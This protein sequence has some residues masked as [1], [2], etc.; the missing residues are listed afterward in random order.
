M[1]S[2]VRSPRTIALTLTVAALLASSS[3]TRAQPAPAEPWPDGESVPVPDLEAEWYRGPLGWIAVEEPGFAARAAREMR[4]AA[5]AWERHFGRPAPKGAVIDV[6]FADRTRAMEE[7]GADWVLAYPF[8]RVAEVAGEARREDGGADG[9]ED[10]SAA[11]RSEI[12]ARLEARG[13]DKSDDEI[14]GMVE[15]AL[16]RTS[17]E[18]SRSPTPDTRR[19]LRHEIGHDLFEALL[20]PSGEEETDRYGTGAPDWLDETAAVLMEGPGHTESRREVFLRAVEAGETIPLAE[21]FE[22]E[23]PLSGLDELRAMRGSTT[24]SGGAVVL[25]GEEIDARLGRSKYF[26]AQARGLADFLLKRSGEP[27]LLA[28]ITRALRSG[29]A[30]DEWLGREGA[31]HGLPAS[32]PALEDAFLAWARTDPYGG[33]G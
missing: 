22:M 5:R 11:I 10:R 15:R 21:F 1:A 3:A 33:D 19:A 27:T 8:R 26:Y 25:S 29:S 31:D 24:G 7:A 6:A 13:I 18:G 4:A 30:V 32:V 9:G 2:F 17:D 14:D 20:W 28:D 23:H 12:E 16:S